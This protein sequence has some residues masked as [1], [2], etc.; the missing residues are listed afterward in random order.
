MD[1]DLKFDEQKAM[2]VSLDRDLK[3]HGDE[4]L[5]VPRRR[6]LLMMWISHMQRIQ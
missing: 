6:S 5:L 2:R 1:R 4:E 3:L